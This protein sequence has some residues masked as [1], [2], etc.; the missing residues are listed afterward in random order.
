MEY[1][2]VDLGNGRQGLRRVRQPVPSNRSDLACPMIVTGF[3]KPVQSMANGRFYDTARGLEATY[4][5]SGNPSGQEF[6]QLGNET[7]KP[8]EAKPDVRQRRDHIRQAIRDV[9]SGNVPD[10]IASIT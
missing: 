3:D 2:W 4:K 7:M 9:K 1:D 10:E 6:V 8:A 5:A